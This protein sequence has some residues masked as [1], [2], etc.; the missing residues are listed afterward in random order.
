M[1]N[2]QKPSAW[3]TV[4]DGLREDYHVLKIRRDIRRHDGDG[5]VG[6]FVIIDTPHW[7]NILPIT[8]DGNVVLVEQFRQGIR[9]LSLEIPGGLVDAT[10]DP[11]DAAE[12]ECTEE[13][14][15]A[16]SERAELLGE[17]HPNPAYQSTRCSLFVWNGCK[18]VSEQRLDDGEDIRIVEMPMDEMLEKVRNGTIRHALV[19][20]AVALWL[21]QKK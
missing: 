16:S 7:V 11:R 14:G 18:R 4:Q 8:V 10:E 1:S 5:R 6:E 15:F 2:E 17:I 3:T 21:L 13:T 20:G 9:A 12:R 19:L